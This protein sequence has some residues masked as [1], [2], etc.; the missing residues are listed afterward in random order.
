MTVVPR[1]EVVWAHPRAQSLTATI[2][3]DVVEALGQG[4]ADVDVL[5]LYRSGFDP[6]LREPD[7]PDEGDLDRRYS[8]EV[9]GQAER[10]R[11]YDTLMERHLNIG[12]AG[13]AR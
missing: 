8:D 9:M 2:A 13:H 6:V 11:G 4:G 1:I 5:D 7:E 3:G 10:M 12:L